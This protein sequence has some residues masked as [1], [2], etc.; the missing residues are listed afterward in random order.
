MSAPCRLVALRLG[1]PMDG[2]T[3]GTYSG[4]TAQNIVYT[5]VDGKVKVNMVLRSFK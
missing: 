5:D 1:Q 3:G 4:L 2:N